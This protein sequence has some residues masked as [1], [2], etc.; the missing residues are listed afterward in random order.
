MKLLYV[1]VS[2]K[3]DCYYEQA[4]LSVMSAKYQMPDIS[5][6]LLMDDKTHRSLEKERIDILKYVDDIKVIEFEASV[7]SMVRS[8]SLKTLMREHVSGDFLYVDVD[9]LWVG[10]IDE[11]D[12]NSDIMG[13]PDGNVDFASFI[14][15]DHHLE[16]SKK[17][18]FKI[19]LD[20]FINGGV[21]FLK[22]SPI[23]HEFM[24]EWNQWWTYSLSHDVP[25]DQ[26]SLNYVNSYKMGI[27]K[28]LPNSY[29]VQIDFS[30][31]YLLG[32]K[33]IH[34]FS[35]GIQMNESEMF[36]ELKKYSF[37]EK[38][39]K[40]GNYIKRMNDIVRNPNIYFSSS[41]VKLHI[42]LGDMH[43]VPAYGFML[44]LMK[45]QNWR[46]KILLKLFNSFANCVSFLFSLN[47][48]KY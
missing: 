32:A 3:T 39:Q 11:K 14:W 13:V 12:F 24:S 10:T 9:T 17:L 41:M 45:Y 35:S 26:Q 16:L 21:L 22:D 2:Q 19:D 40:E 31:R 37:W 36:F 47:K 15:K 1:L 18:N 34:Y 42:D 7:N 4:L 33:I 8:R 29:N 27:I 30:I 23:A 28:K 5:I 6:T 43:N 44:D 38:L 25:T 46:G 48:R 20:Y